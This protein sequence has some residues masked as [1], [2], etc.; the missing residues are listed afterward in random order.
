M[1]ISP[2]VSV[3]VILKQKSRYEAQRAVLNV[4]SVGLYFMPLAIDFVFCLINADVSQ[5]TGFA[6]NS[7]DSVLQHVHELRERVVMQQRRVREQKYF[8]CFICLWHGF[9]PF[10]SYPGMNVGQGDTTAHTQRKTA[11]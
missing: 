5:H 8:L 10:F 6:L 7:G 4:L 9:L 1:G 2:S 11:L 3:G